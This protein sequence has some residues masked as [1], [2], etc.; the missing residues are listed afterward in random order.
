M[1]ELFWKV[2]ATGQDRP[3]ISENKDI[4][5]KEFNKRR[6]QVF[7][8]I[9]LGY[10]LFYVLR[11]NFSVI[12]KPI[13]ADG[14][15]NAQDLGIMGSVFFITYG[16][17]KFINSF[18]A[19]RMNNKRFFAFGLFISSIVTVLMGFCNQFLPLVVLW[20]INGWFQSFGAGPCIVS[21][22]QWFSNKERGTYYG[23]WFTSHNLGAAFTYVAT[24]TIVSAYSWH[25]GFVMPGIF[26]LVGS[27]LIYFFMHDR[28]ESYGLPNAEEFK[29]DGDVQ[30]AR[31]EKD[32]SVASLQWSVVKRPAV[33][34]LG[35]SSLC[36]YIAR[37]AIESW[38]IIY[39][40][41]AK[42]YTTIG[43]SGVLGVMQFAGI[44]GA[45]TCGLVS[46]KFFNHKRNM[47]AL[48]YGVLYA[49]AIAAFLWAPA[50]PMT[51]MI[52]MCVYGFTMGALVC[53]LGGLMA[54]DICPK[55]ATGAAMGMIGL[56]S[57]FGA[58][59]QEMVSGYLINAHMTIVNGKKVYDF[60]LAG[61]FWVGA[62][63]ASFVLAA[64]VWNVKAND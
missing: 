9:T 29:N 7:A 20:G 10:A 56:L 40:T 39:L 54:V 26:C 3:L 8:S 5:S 16:L 33:W 51:D 22:N 31:A 44:F 11:L 48:I 36:C 24:A 57:Y 12:K 64:L 21:L 28:P 6:W 35:L 60:A 52:T 2:F 59:M 32:K 55:R 15:L 18:L 30:A 1:L 46:D 61:D 23:I 47:P 13:M 41:E 19:D 17:G 14:V 34:I 42:G 62:A 53:Y 58:A 45:L 50:N 25:M 27:I 38:G 37:Y 49:A 63:V 43:A 4:I